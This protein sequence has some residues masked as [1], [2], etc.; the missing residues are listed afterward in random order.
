MSDEMRKAIE[1]MRSFM[2]ASGRKVSTRDEHEK[3]LV[4]DLEKAF[5]EQTD[6]L[7]IAI[8]KYRDK[9][10]FELNKGYLLEFFS[11]RPFMNEYMYNMKVKELRD[12]GEPQ[13]YIHTK[14]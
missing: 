1:D 7:K 4:S 9:R 3:Y 11:N 6:R 14:G 5:A 10:L 8:K 12:A 2:L 13:S